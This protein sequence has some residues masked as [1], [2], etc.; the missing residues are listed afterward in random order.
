ML[1]SRKYHKPIAHMGI[2]RSVLNECYHLLVGVIRNWLDLGVQVRLRYV[3]WT[4]V[5]G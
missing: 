1:Q 3:G 2:L 5:L 4:K